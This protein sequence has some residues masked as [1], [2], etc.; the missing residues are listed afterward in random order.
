[1]G[2]RV[3]A[4][5]RRVGRRGVGWLLQLCAVTLGDVDVDVDGLGW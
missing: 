5:L 1:M 4:S 3:R 2:E